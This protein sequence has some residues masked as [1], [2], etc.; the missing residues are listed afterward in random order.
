MRLARMARGAH[1]VLPTFSKRCRV[2]LL[3]LAHF[4][5]HVPEDIIIIDRGLRLAIGHPIEL[6]HGVERLVGNS[7]R[8]TEVEECRVAD[9]ASIVVQHVVVVAASGNE[10]AVVS[11]E[12]ARSQSVLT[13]GELHA[14]NRVHCFER[15][16]CHA[17]EV[18]HDRGNPCGEQRCKEGDEERSR[19]VAVEINGA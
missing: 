10:G 11:K 14:T 3:L 9:V 19:L 4:G 8:Q 1:G 5:C 2:G 12:S 16:L 15:N 7:D 17:E 13:S 18:V 6:V